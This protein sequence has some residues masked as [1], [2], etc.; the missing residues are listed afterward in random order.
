MIQQ[1]LR[2]YD[3]DRDSCPRQAI[4]S[5]SSRSACSGDALADALVP[6]TGANCSP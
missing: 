3:T 5:P 6:I 4:A 2:Y 1:H